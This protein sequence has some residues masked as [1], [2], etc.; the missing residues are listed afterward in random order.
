MASRVGSR[1]QR[2][3]QLWKLILARTLNKF[4]LLLG[5][6]CLWLISSKLNKIAPSSLLLP[7]QHP[8]SSNILLTIAFLTQKILFIYS[9]FEFCDGLRSLEAGAK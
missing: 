9:L 6:E 7:Y 4:S 5:L 3:V 1:G 8:S 2:Q